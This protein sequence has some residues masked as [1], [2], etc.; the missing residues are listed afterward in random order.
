MVFASA[1]RAFRWLVLAPGLWRRAE[2]PVELIAARAAVL[3]VAFG[4]CGVW[5]EVVYGGPWFSAVGGAVGWAVAMY[6][7]VIQLMIQD[8]IRGYR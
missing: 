1:W 2:M 3:A 7:T 8:S 5:L 4:G 6:T